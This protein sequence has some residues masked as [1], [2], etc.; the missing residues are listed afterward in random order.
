MTAESHKE[1]SGGN[2]YMRVEGQLRV[3]EADVKTLLDRTARL[4]ERM[5]AQEATAQTASSRTWDIIKFVLTAVI[6]GAIG[7]WLATASHKI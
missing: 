1:V 4:E 2:F 7:A 3:I 5:N 6:A